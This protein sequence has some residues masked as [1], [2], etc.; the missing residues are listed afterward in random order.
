MKYFEVPNS[1]TWRLSLIQD[2]LGFK[3]ESVDIPE[4]SSVE[5]EEMLDFVCISQPSCY[6]W[7]TMVGFPLGAPVS[8]TPATQYH[9][10]SSPN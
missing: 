9:L 3:S 10:F 8:P 1:E 7:L 4:F 5:V 6:P 2:L